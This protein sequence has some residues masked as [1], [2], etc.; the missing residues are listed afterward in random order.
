MTMGG[1]M[2]VVYQF[3]DLLADNV[4]YDAGGLDGWLASLARDVHHLRRIS[5]VF[6]HQK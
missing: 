1:G 6:V 2:R 5:G 3:Y 4:F